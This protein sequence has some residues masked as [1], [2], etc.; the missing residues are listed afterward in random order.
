[1]ST[2]IGRFRLAARD[3]RRFADKQYLCH[4]SIPGGEAL[5]DEDQHTLEKFNAC[6]VGL[7]EE[8]VLTAERYTVSH[9]HCRERACEIPLRENAETLLT[10]VETVCLLLEDKSVSLCLSDVE[11]IASPEGAS[12]DFFMTALRACRDAAIAEAAATCGGLASEANAWIQDLYAAT[13]ELLEAFCI[14]D[15]SG[16]IGT[17]PADYSIALTDWLKAFDR[18]APFANRQRRGVGGRKRKYNGELLKKWQAHLESLKH[19]GE[20]PVPLKG[21]LREQAKQEGVPLR[22]LQK[23]WK[24]EQRQRTRH[25]G[26]TAA[27]WR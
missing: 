2:A 20:K 4:P 6:V 22:E 1:M 21:W 17:P 11:P 26:Q 7:F 9:L 15:Q 8:G 13:R 27:T 3:A 24:A 10:V 25:E 23:R 19:R 14:Y 12:M 5:N 18:L 16:Q